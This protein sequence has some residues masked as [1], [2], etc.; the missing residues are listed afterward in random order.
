MWT[1]FVQHTAGQLVPAERDAVA[2]E[3]VIEIDLEIFFTI[4]QNRSFDYFMVGADFGVVE[5]CG[6]ALAWAG[7]D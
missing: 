3:A 6:N 4:V 5:R 1:S 2:D 7:V